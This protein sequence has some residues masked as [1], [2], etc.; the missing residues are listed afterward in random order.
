MIVTHSPRTG[1]KGLNVTAE[2]S[3]EKR[4]SC[5]LKA[6]FFSVPIFSFLVVYWP[7]RVDYVVYLD[8]INITQ[9]GSVV[10]S[11]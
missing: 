5:N 8:R 7:L 2:Q 1:F 3:D 10:D 4:C 11:R 9:R 6:H